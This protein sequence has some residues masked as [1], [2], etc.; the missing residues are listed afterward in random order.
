MKFMNIQK[1]ADGAY[2]ISAYSEQTIVSSYSEQTIV[3][4]CWKNHEIVE[5]EG[6]L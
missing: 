6:K 5:E 1:I 2:F 4:D 3:A